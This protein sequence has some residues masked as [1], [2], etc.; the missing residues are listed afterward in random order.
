MSRVPPHLNELA[1]VLFVVIV[2][3]CAEFHRQGTHAL[4]VLCSPVQEIL[5]A[6]SPH[7]LSFCFRLLVSFSF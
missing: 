6:V 5:V 4:I 2:P 1:V 7:G 3:S